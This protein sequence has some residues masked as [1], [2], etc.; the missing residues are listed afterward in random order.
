MGWGF[1]LLSL[2]HIEVWTK[3][4]P[5]CRLHNS[6]LCTGSKLSYLHLCFKLKLSFTQMIIFFVKSTVISLAQ[7]L[8]I[9]TQPNLCKPGMTGHPLVLNKCSIKQWSMVNL[10]LIHQY[11]VSQFSWLHLVYTDWAVWY[12]YNFCWSVSMWISW[13]D[14][15]IMI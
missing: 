2:N 10:A 1:L 14:K 5:F 12:M 3:W 8:V 15:E 4:L 7:G 11:N 6:V 9:L 13:K